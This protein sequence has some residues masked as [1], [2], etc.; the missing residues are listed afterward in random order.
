M[1]KRD[2]FLMAGLLTFAGLSYLLLIKGREQTGNRIVITLDG[3]IYGTYALN[4]D[5]EIE[6]KNDN[7]YNVVVIEDGQVYMK[8]AD[9]PDQY[10]VKQG[11]IS[12]RHESLICLPHKLIVEVEIAE[13][14][15]AAA[16]DAIDSIAR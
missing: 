16:E 8:E 13:E 4:Q 15:G 7:G 6:V 12:G 1:N 10:C 9:C 2:V 11:R 3:E 14:D 5:R